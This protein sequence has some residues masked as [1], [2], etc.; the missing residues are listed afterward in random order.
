MQPLTACIR[1]RMF[2]FASLSPFFAV[3]TVYKWKYA[4]MLYSRLFHF[5]IRSMY[6]FCLYNTQ[7][8]SNVCEHTEHS[9]QT[10]I[11]TLPHANLLDL[12][13]RCVFV[14]VAVYSF[15]HSTLSVFVPNAIRCVSALVFYQQLRDYDSY[16]SYG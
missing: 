13:I 1:V 6:I 14:V 8:T 3:P 10:G 5:T 2:C 7:T 11:A 15:L 4:C 12:Y 16:I 9:Q